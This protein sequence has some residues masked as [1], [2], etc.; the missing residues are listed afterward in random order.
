M[1]IAPASGEMGVL[2]DID[3]LGCL[4]YV[5]PEGVEVDEGSRSGCSCVGNSVADRTFKK[6]IP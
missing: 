6:R 1:V 2:G 3:E 5:E 4:L